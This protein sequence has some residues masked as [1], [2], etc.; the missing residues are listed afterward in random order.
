M[1]KSNIDPEDVVKDLTHAL[2]L[3]SQIENIDLNKVDL[4]KFAEDVEVI[5]TNL[6]E[7]YKDVLKEAEDD[8]DSK[9]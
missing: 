2:N 6:K 4:N 1:K 7:K 3:I 9:E 5:E 8:L